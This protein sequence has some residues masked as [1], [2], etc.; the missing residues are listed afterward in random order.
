MQS[1]QDDPQVILSQAIGTV[2]SQMALAWGVTC[3]EQLVVWFLLW[4]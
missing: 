3:C 4:F 2:E 1:S